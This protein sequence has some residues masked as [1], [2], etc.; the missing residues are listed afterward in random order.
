MTNCEGAVRSTDMCGIA[1]T[2]SFDR[3]S[4]VDAAAL[5]EAT[6]VIAHRGPDDEGLWTGSGVG[7]GARR[8]AVIDLSE[9]GHQPM[10]N[11]DGSVWIAFNGEIYNYQEIRRQLVAQGHVFRSNTDTETIVHLYEEEGIDAL[12]RLR[13][14][15]AVALWDSR[16]ETFFLVRDRLGKKPLFYYQDSHRLVFGSEIKCILRAGVPAIPDREAVHHYLTFGYVPAPWSAFQQIRKLPPAHFLRVSAGR[17]S[18][19][20][21]WQPQYQAQRTESEEAL[22]EELSHLLEESTRLRM[23]SDVP[24]GV[25]LSGGLDSSA[26]VAMMR[27][28][29]SGPIR[30]F[31]IGFEQP[32]YDELTYARQVAQRFDAEHHELVVRPHAV[33]MVPRLAWHY[34]EPFA[35]SSAIPSFAVCELARRSVTVALNGDGGDEVFL[36]YDRYVA[37]RLALHQ[38]WCPAP[39][40]R[41]L[42]GVAARLPLGTPKS[43]LYRVRRF[44]AGFARSPLA[45][46]ESWIEVFDDE[47]K[48]E[49]LSPDFTGYGRSMRLFEAAFQQSDGRTF[50][51]R[52]AHADLQTYLPDDLLVKMD[53]A[54][55]AH[56]LEVRSP[57][58]DHH[59]VE[60]AASLPLRMK[61]RRSTQK[62]LLR[63]LLRDVLPPPVLNRRKM[64][65][66]VPIDRWFRHELRDMAYDLL[67]DTQATTRGYFRPNVVRRYLDE[68]SR[69]VAHHHSKLWAL[70]MLE[71]WHRVFIDEACPLSPPAPG[72]VLLPL[73]GVS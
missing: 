67:L 24:L 17:V 9:R 18:V 59:I 25:L 50:V 43:T 12:K 51:E 4:A 38:S 22:L 30:T 2:F 53:I 45:Q 52:I 8:L 63:R 31:S 23:I 66:G 15:F 64:G 49:L 69:G 44:A 36:G 1:G 56:S 5:G 7:L 46:Y 48:Q 60:F 33:N 68:H 42:A 40:R 20:R 32:E 71:V 58:L 10:S 29:S 21:Y 35:D 14:M 72:H 26:V 65:F 3:A 11:E 13:G 28:V 16:S 61:L 37:A 41:L 57:L 73:G 27:R 55:M 19:E 47:A 34:N 6:R 70:L 39:A 54:S 62:Y